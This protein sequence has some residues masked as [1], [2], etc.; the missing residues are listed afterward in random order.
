MLPSSGFSVTHCIRPDFSVYCMVHIKN[1]NLSIIYTH[2]H[3]KLEIDKTRR[4]Y[5]R[6]TTENS[7]VSVCIC[8]WSPRVCVCMCT[9]VCISHSL[10]THAAS[11]W[12]RRVKRCSSSRRSDMTEA[13]MQA[14]VRHAAT[15]ACW[16]T[17]GAASD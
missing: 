1:L 7:L 15:V 16:D 13:H 2:T 17:H 3:K 11:S 12:L 8:C 4:C 6:Q 9:H 14:L 10:R 5:G